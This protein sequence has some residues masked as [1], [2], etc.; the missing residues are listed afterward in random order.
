MRNFDAESVDGSG[1][2]KRPMFTLL[3]GDGTGPQPRP[4]GPDRHSPF[5]AAVVESPGLG[6]SAPGL[7]SAALPHLRQDWAQ[8]CCHICTGT[9]RALQYRCRCALLL[10]ATAAAVGLVP[11]CV[12]CAL[13]DHP[14]DVLGTQGRDRVDAGGPSGAA[15][16]LAGAVWF[17]GAAAHRQDTLTTERG[18]PRHQMGDWTCNEKHMLR[19]LGCSGADV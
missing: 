15:P 4:T 13:S 14:R 9:G 12:S 1:V 16:S 17:V 8:P 3:Q 18:T 10:H 19:Q 7:G 2:A 11:S 5:W 6:T